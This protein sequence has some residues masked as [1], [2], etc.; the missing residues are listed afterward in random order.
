[1]SAIPISELSVESLF[2]D[3]LTSSLCV[4]IE[5]GTD[6]WVATGML[7]QQLESFT[8]AVV[9][10]ENDKPI[11][12]VGGKDIIV[13]LV[14][15]P[16]SSLFYD[17]KVEDVME[18]RFPTV[19]EKSKLKE[20]INYWKETRR[21]FAA[22]PNEFSDYSSLSAKKMLE[23]GMKVKTGITV[24]QLPKK[25]LITFNEK[26][27]IGDVLNLMLKIN[28]RRLVLAN[29]NKFI[30]DRI[31]LQKITD[32]LKCLK[33]TE[34]FMGL[35][36]SEFNLEEVTSISEDLT[37]QEISKIMYEME[38]PSALYQDQIITPWDICLI[39]LSENITEYEN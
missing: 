9:V 20:V 3:S 12:I 2:G 11:G 36:I 28:T 16:N 18:K 5:K 7:V 4:N 39:L 37:I 35:S 15:N 14:E 8:D 23:V 24:S 19:T 22:V 34:N 33:E 29:S 26:D 6:T 38:H 10:R 32:E 17:T 13:P 30:N 21:A 27:I 31:I 25:E 1:M